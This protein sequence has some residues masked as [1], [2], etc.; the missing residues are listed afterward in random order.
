MKIIRQL[1]TIAA[2]GG[3]P[4]SWKMDTSPL[5]SEIGKFALKR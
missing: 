5:K 1:L 3:S 4:L 2:K